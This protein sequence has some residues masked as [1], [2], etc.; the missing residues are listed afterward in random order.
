MK[1]VQIIT[2]TVVAMITILGFGVNAY[3]E[4]KMEKKKVWPMVLSIVLILVYTIAMHNIYGLW[5]F[6]FTMIS[7]CVLGNVGW[8]LQMFDDSRFGKVTKAIDVITLVIMVY[9]VFTMFRTVI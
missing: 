7:V 5:K 2:G 6:T 8:I 3:I 9:L 1:E 4:K